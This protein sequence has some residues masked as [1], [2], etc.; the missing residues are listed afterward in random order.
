LISGLASPLHGAEDERFANVQAVLPQISGF[1][2]GFGIAV[3]VQQP[4]PDL[5]P[6]ASLQAEFTRTLSPPSDSFSGLAGDITLKVS[7]FTLAGYLVWTSPI[8]EKTSWHGK[9]GLLYESITVDANVDL[10][11]FEDEFTISESGSGIGISYGAGLTYLM[12]DR[13]KFIAEYTVIEADISHISGGFQ[14]SF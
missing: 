6:N 9:I 5:H 7:Y 3:A 14:F 12:D 4:R 13:K 8:N 1:G 10:E 2:G 11:G